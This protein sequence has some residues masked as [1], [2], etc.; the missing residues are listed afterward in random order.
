MSNHNKRIA[1][2]GDMFNGLE[3]SGPGRCV[4]DSEVSIN[5]IAKGYSITIRKNNFPRR[6][7]IAVKGNNVFFKKDDNGWTVS[8]HKESSRSNNGKGNNGYIQI[9]KNTMP[10]LERFVGNY[11]L[12]YFQPLDTWYIE[13]KEDN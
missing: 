3:W 10:D 12:Q 5:R 6:V 4:G 13:K 8:S 9:A 1:S 2:V 7:V 11:K